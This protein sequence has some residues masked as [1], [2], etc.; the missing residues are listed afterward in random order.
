MSVADGRERFGGGNM[1]SELS[2]AAK[3]FNNQGDN[4]APIA[5][6]I[7][8]GPPYHGALAHLATCG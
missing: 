6:S 8:C 1:P 4:D 3:I 5:A 2:L 7:W